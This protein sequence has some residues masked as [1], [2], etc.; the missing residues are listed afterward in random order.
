MEL[1]SLKARY[2][3]QHE[4]KSFHNGTFSGVW[5][6]HRT[7]RTPYHFSDGVTLYVSEDEPDADQD[8][9]RRRGSFT[10]AD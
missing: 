4:K 7:E 10:T 5:S 9:L 3:A 8:F 1:A 6:E 2:A